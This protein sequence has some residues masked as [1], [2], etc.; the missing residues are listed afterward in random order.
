MF[1]EGRTRRSEMVVAG[2][3]SGN[4]PSRYSSSFPRLDPGSLMCGETGGWSRSRTGGSGRFFQSNRSFRP[5]PA[6]QGMKMMGSRRCSTFCGFALPHPGHPQGMPLRS[7]WRSAVRPRRGTSPRTTFFCVHYRRSVYF[8]TDHP[9]QPAPA[10]QGMR[11]GD[12]C[13]KRLRVLRDP[14]PPL[15]I[16]ARHRRIRDAPS[17]E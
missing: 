8:R 6:H 10:H 11:M 14:S 17:R 13:G 1:C 9:S 12:P 2:P 5:A 7:C 4:K 3:L 16:P 15:R